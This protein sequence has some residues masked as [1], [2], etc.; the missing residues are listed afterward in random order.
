[1]TTSRSFRRGPLL[2]MLGLSLAPFVAGCGA[3]TTESVDMDESIAS[4][5]FY[6]LEVQSLEGDAVPLERYRGQVS[7]VVNTASKCGLT[8]QYE[9]LEALQQEFADRGFT[10]L[11][12]PSGDFGGQE[13]D[14]AG[15]IRE[16]CDS[17]YAVTFPL[18][19]KSGVKEGPDQ[20]EV[21]RFLGGATGSLPGWNFG[22]YLVDREGTVLA[23][24]APTVG[25]QSDEVRKALEA[26]LA[27]A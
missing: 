7:L 4:Q 24:F 23:F 11:G 18:F 12:F 22:K 13:F 9:G 14:S 21:F 25:P 10:V 26:A 17:K 27:D 6:A 1:M 5:S 15:E 20:S 8:P 19:A 3:I 2:C 16:F